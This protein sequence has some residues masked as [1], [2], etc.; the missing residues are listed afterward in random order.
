[1]TWKT[2]LEQ[3]IAEAGSLRELARRMQLE[4]PAKISRW[5]LYGL[6][7]SPS[8]Q[9]KLAMAT[10]TSLEEI[11]SLVWNAEAEREQARERRFRPTSGGRRLVG[12][13]PK[14]TPAAP[15]RIRRA[16]KAMGAMLMALL[17]WGWAPAH[18][19]PLDVSGGPSPSYRT[20]RTWPLVLQPA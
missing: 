20:R 6:L 2:K 19:Q 13:P 1:M 5:R 7:P 16:R 10:H 18:A 8:D 14:S 12:L 4:D 11:K 17:P 9:V 15:R 3:L